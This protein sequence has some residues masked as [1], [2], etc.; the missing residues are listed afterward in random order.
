MELSSRPNKASDKLPDLQTLVGRNWVS[1]EQAS[2]L[3][4]VSYQTALKLIKPGKDKLGHETPARLKAIRVGGTWRIYEEE[5]RRY[6][7][8]GN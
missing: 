1:L 4:E 6:L 5:L 7:D 2:K 8:S 3:L